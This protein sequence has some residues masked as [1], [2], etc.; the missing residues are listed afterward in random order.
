ML[1]PTTYQAL[2]QGVIQDA[3]YKQHMMRLELDDAT[4]AAIINYLLKD[5]EN[6]EDRVIGVFDKLKTIIYHQLPELRGEQRRLVIRSARMT[7]GRGKWM[8]L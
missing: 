2:Y 3:D 5:S 4:R 6:L 8:S 7:F 1:C